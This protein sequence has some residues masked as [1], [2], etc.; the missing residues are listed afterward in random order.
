MHT[1][2]NDILN[3]F[4]KSFKLAI[5]WD[6]FAEDLGY[7]NSGIE[8]IDIQELHYRILDNNDFQML[9]KEN[10]NAGLRSEYHLFQ[11]NT[12]NNIGWCY[13]RIHKDRYEEMLAEGMLNE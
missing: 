9:I 3:D 1:L 4:L 6:Y 10:C 11:R 13:D 12:N 8:F 2:T 7:K 5:H